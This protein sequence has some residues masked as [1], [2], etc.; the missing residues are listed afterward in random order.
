M[1]SETALLEEIP[2][3]PKLLELD[4]ETERRLEEIRRKNRPV[5]VCATSFGT[6][7]VCGAIFWGNLPEACPKCGRRF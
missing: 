5:W 6:G 4:A 3:I 7:N 2:A 1:D